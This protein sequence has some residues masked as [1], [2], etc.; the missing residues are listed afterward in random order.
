MIINLQRLYIILIVVV[1]QITRWLK[2]FFR[3]PLEDMQ[4]ESVGL[5]YNERQFGQNRIVSSGKQ[6][7]LERKILIKIVGMSYII[8]KIHNSIII[9][10]ITNII[11]NR[12]I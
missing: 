9:K 4:V 5:R 8:N 6:K 3:T 2:T 7:A 12:V 11:R 1:I 10:Y